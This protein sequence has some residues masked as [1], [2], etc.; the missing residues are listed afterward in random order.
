MLRPWSAQTTS[1][2]FAERRVVPEALFGASLPRLRRVK[3]AYDPQ[4]RIRGNHPVRPLGALALVLL[5]VAVAAL[6]SGFGGVCAVEGRVLESPRLK[7][8]DTP[9][10]GMQT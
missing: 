4:D 6:P 5:A 1:L 3:T 7:S 10:D 9:R 2:N 8:L